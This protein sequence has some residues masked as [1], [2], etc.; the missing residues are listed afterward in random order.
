M[1]RIGSEKGEVTIITMA[2]SKGQSLRTTIPMGIAKQFGLKDKQRLNWT[3]Q[4][5]D[6][7]MVIVVVPQEE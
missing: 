1:A 4:V 7:K 6:N 2:T 5:M 3:I